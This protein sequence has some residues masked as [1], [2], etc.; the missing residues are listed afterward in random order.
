MKIMDEEE[1]RIWGRERMTGIDRW[2]YCEGAQ[3]HAR[4]T[5][6]YAHIESK[7]CKKK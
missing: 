3:A 1:E 6:K 5:H 2:Y 4:N 7:R